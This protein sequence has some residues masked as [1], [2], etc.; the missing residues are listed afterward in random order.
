MKTI[1]AAALLSAAEAYHNYGSS[2]V[3][4]GLSSYGGYSHYVSPTYVRPVVKYNVCGHH[5]SSEDSDAE[6]SDCDIFTSDYS[7]NDHGLGYTRH[8]GRRLYYRYV[9]RYFN[10]RYI[11]GRAFAYTNGVYY[12]RYQYYPVRSYRP[13]FYYLTHSIPEVIVPQQRSLEF[14]TFNASLTTGFNRDFP[15][16]LRI[17]AVSSGIASIDADVMCLQ[18]IYTQDEIDDVIAA[19]RDPYSAWKDAEIFYV[20]TREEI[21]EVP[22]GSPTDLE[23]AAALGQCFADNC[24]AEPDFLS[25]CILESCGAQLQAPS[26][27]CQQCL[28]TGSQVNNQLSDRI[29]ECTSEAQGTLI[30]G[31]NDGTMLVSKKPMKN[32]D[33]IIPDPWAIQY[34]SLYAEIEGVQV[35]C[36]HSAKQIF[37]GYNGEYDS[38]EGQNFYETGLMM[39]L[40]NEK[41]NGSPQVL[42]GDF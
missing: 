7:D 23:A 16:S 15:T 34:S 12:G 38:Y 19:L 11:Y 25:F 1:F 31:G 3:Q 13:T 22:C 39:D 24:S 30:F 17:D 28:A 5:T 40:L 14:A 10:S 32:K 8:H 41:E 6:R 42:L 35:L 33:S 2:Y 21:A 29:G 4:H 20:D 27:T 36:S 26:P 37:A 18:E 9:P